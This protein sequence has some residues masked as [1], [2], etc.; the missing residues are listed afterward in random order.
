[1]ASL[2]WKDSYRIGVEDIDRQHKNLFILLG[3]LDNSIKDGQHNPMV[4]QALKQLVDYSV[5]HFREEEKVMVMVGYP[6]FDNHRKQ[7]REFVAQLT[8]ILKDLKEG[9]DITASKLLE[10]LHNWLVDHILGEDVKIAYAVQAE[11]RD[12]DT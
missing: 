9:K 6:D 2:E 3:K 4:G 7:H 8:G 1:M 10:F 11:E 12:L 5:T